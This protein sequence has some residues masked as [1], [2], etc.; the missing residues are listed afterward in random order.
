MKLKTFLPQSHTILII[1]TIAIGL[2]TGIAFEL[3]LIDTDQLNGILIFYSIGISISLLAYD[4]FIDLAD[5]KIF[6]S[7][8][9]IGLIQFL[10]Y[11]ATR[12][13]IEFIT[14]HSPDFDPDKG[15]NRYLTDSA[16]TSLKTLFVFL[17]F[18]KIC[19]SI[20]ARITGENLVNTYHKST[21]MNNTAKRKIMVLDVFFNILLYLIVIISILTG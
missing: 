19:N 4:T 20:I 15:I 2:I 1:C 11:F 12:N 8:L 10:I 17:I 6:F 5:N 14:V 18:Y 7:W 9:L 16:T 13:K 3:H 21:W